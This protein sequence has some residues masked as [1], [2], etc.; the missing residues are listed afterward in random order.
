MIVCQDDLRHST[1]TVLACPECGSPHVSCVLWPCHWHECHAC[2][3]ADPV[4]L[5]PG[6]Q[7]D[8]EDAQ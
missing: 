7:N 1:V 8:A 4:D 2:G 3:G 5:W 6:Q